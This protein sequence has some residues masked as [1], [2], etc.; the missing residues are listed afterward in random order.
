MK[1]I[2]QDTTPILDSFAGYLEKQSR[3]RFTLGLKHIA[4]KY[5]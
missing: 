3:N 1:G 4:L 2:F 5:I